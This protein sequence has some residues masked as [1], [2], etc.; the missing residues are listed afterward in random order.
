MKFDLVPDATGRRT[1]S[2]RVQ[3]PADD[4]NPADNVR[5][6]DI[7][8]VDRKTH[9]LLLADGPMREYQ[10]LRNQLYRDRYT[11]V[12]VLLQSGKPGMSQEA[13]KILDDFPSTARG[14]VRLRLHRGLR[15]RLET[16]EGRPNRVAGKVGRR[17]GRRLDR[18]GRAGRRLQRPR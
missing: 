4:R 1:L 18:H 14:D 2:L 5:E 3:A 13:K 16:A 8:I 15:P 6:A 17:A 7:E 10:F 11:T 9:V 12:D